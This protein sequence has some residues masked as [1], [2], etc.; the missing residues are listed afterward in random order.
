MTKLSKEIKPFTLYI[1]TLNA[2]LGTGIFFLPALGA[3][4]AGPA[5]LISWIII[6][7]ISI[8]ISAYFG[9]LV[10]MFPRS[11]GIFEFVKNSFGEKTTFFVGWT[12]WIVA[13]ITTAMLV[14][15]ALTYLYS[16]LPL[17]W[18]VLIAIA[19]ILLFN[20]INY[21]GIR[22]SSKMLL[23]FG[24]ITLSVLISLIIP[25]LVNTNINNFYPFFIFPFSSI[26]IAMFYIAETF[27]GWETTT[28]LAEEA[29]NASKV[30]PKILILAT[31]TIAVLGILLTIAGI[32][33]LGWETFSASKI[34]MSTLA[35]HLF[36]EFHHI[37]SILIFITIMG[38]A[39]GWIVS[40]P[41]LLYAMAR[42]NLFIKNVE[43]VHKKYKTPHFAILL[44]TLV[45]CIVTLIAFANYRTLLSLLMP[46]VLIIYSFVLASIFKLRKS[47]HKRFFNAPLKSIIP[48][49][50]IL[51]NIYLICVWFS[52]P[53]SFHLIGLDI[54]L[55]L[56]GIPAYI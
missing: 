37:F 12:S 51:F 24:F 23:L 35:A 55:I 14:V 6:S 11:G 25:G 32:G 33:V 40:S 48:P 28:F 21:K 52:Q 29:K 53:E 44:Q 54:L 8:F 27:F 1:L 39:A 41:R 18:N 31:A 43:K 3:L 13:N 22:N 19:F 50:L 2:I 30:L 9:E 7:I 20:F 17:V 38:S 4:Y 15:G 45:T 42:D 56:S 26:F 10:S 34:P 46:L 16:E 47:K 49:L 5:S 36:G